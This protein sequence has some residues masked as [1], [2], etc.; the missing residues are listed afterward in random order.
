MDYKTITIAFTGDIAFDKYMDGRHNDKEL[1]SDGIYDFLGEADHVV[2]NLEGA[3]YKPSDG[4]CKSKYFHAMDPRVVCALKRINADIWNLANNHIMDAGEQGLVSTLKI[5]HANNCKTVGAGSDTTEASKP[6][7]IDNGRFGIGMISVGYQ[8]E[9]KAASADTAGCLSWN[10]F[11]LISNRI[12]EIKKR[13]RWCV[14]VSHGGEEFAP[15]P[16]PYT[17]EIYKKY[18]SF[19]ADAVV[20]H[21]PHVPE[22]YEVFEDGKMIFYS[23]GNFIFDTDYQRVHRYT[24]SGVLLKLKFTKDRFEHEAVGIKLDRVDGRITT[25]DL[26]DIFTDIS[27]KEYELL[28]PLGAKAFIAEDRRKMEYLYPEKYADD[29]KALQKYF[30]GHSHEDYVKGSHMD[31][32]INLPLAKAAENNEWEN[33]RLAIVKKYILGL[34]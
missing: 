32:D 3:L 1:L 19:G 10:D 4:S 21:H 18:L 22:N 8:N 34:L 9:C 26:P 14:V 28:S 7:Y 13:C 15:L 2:V 25:C 24:D 16:L 29:P 17:R 31:F 12:G 6:V 5:A 23:L 33:S 27:A 30:S 11:E 20:A